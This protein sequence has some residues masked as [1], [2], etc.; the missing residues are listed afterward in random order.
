MPSSEQ[1]AYIVQGRAA[2]KQWLKPDLSSSVL[3]P[4]SSFLLAP[5]SLRRFVVLVFMMPLSLVVN[6]L[7]YLNST[8][9]FAWSRWTGASKVVPSSAVV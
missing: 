3:L 5:C 2:W 4:P 1:Q 6:T 7:F 8:I 9:Q